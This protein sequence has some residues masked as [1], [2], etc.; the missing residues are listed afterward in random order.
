[1][2]PSLKTGRWGPGTVQLSNQKPL[3]GSGGSVVA[4]DEQRDVEWASSQAV[5]L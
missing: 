2:V 1:M 4:N 3:R 5:G